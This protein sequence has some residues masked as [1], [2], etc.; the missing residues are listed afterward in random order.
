MAGKSVFKLT[1]RSIRSF[2]GRYM[3]LLLIVALSVGFFAGLKI[4]RAAMSNTAQ[5]FLDE[6]DFYDFRLI[7]TLGFSDSD[8]GDIEDEE[9]VDSAEGSRTTDALVIYRENVEAYKLISLPKQVNIPQITEGR[10]PKAVNE[11]LA[12]KRIFDKSD[13]GARIEISDRNEDEVTDQ[14]L[15]KEYIIVGL[16]DSPIYLGQDRG[17]TNIGSG[18]LSGFFYIPEA[19]FKT[20]VYTEINLTLKET[21][22]IYSD[23]YDSLIKKYEDRI[24][25]TA[26]KLADERYQSILDEIEDAKSLL[27]EIEDAIK[28]AEE[29]RAAM[30]AARAAM[31]A[32]AQAA[33]QSAMGAEAA[34]SAGGMSFVMPEGEGLGVPD[35]SEIEIPDISESELEELREA[36]ETKVDAPEVYVLTRDENAGYVSFEN[37]TSIIS[38]VANIFPL[39]FILIAMLVCITTMTRMVD[40]E[41]TQIGTLKAMGFGSGT[42]TAK[43]LL[44]AGSATLIGWFVGFFLGTWGLPQVF[45][46][47]YASFYSFAPLSYLFAG[48]LAIVTLAV[49][50]VGILG[51]AWISCRKELISVPAKL[52]RPKG[53]KTGK[54]IFLER[55]TPLW[56]RF[57]FLTKV[58]IRN[59]FR[60]KR[61]LIMMLVGIG[62][63]A[64]LVVTAFGVRDSMIDIGKWQYEEI[65]KYGFEAAFEEDDADGVYEELDKIEDIKSYLGCFNKRV[66]MRA[67]GTLDAVSLYGFAADDTK[68]LSGYWSFHS[69][70]AEITFPSEGEALISMQ[71]AQ[72]LSLSEGDT[73]EIEDSD[74]NTAELKV[75]GIF[76]N[77]IENYV[78]VSDETYKAAFGGYGVN[79]VL[80]NTDEES[81]AKELS[82]RI[83]DIKGITGVSRLESARERI[84]NSVSCLN[85]LIVLIVGFSGA[86]AFIV[87]FNLTN[88]NLAER[89]REI[90]TVEVLGFYKQETES[91]VL[92]EN[93]ILS[94]LAAFIGM[95]LGTVFHRVVMEMVVVKGLAF[96]IHITSL[97]YILAVICTIVFAVVVNMVMKRQISKI[98]MAE[99]LKAIE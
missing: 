67:E 62:C 23:D 73:F 25:D 20:E 88:I 92:H 86:L 32:A 82:E 22:P 11:C 2:L 66:D 43:Y 80:I 78:I 8:V 51:S 26:R 87:I 57:P 60:Y 9:F 90:A 93:L 40:E 96:N 24:T 58:T 36:A 14:L 94:V 18:A 95:P 71:A 37:D 4:T 17:S 19:N 55:I 34:Q 85:Y 74:H 33:A 39:F 38:G 84:D 77:Y 42:I 76:D 44:Y 70:K 1:V 46:Y 54:R 63:C 16:V 27:Q 49:A 52:I 6:H 48:D 28:Q 79:T 12:D 98:K 3:A 53:S 64:G 41:R 81:D 97:S 99:S 69:G 72:M 75:G 83:T 68:T 59:M 91:Y 35:I 21:A 56:R 47:A 89:S 13:I 61:R 31:E 65:Q 29:A 30:E 5:V 50:L 7:S 10:M 45:W 15:N